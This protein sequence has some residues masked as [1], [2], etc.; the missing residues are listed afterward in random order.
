M[1][2]KIVVKSLWMD[3]LLMRLS[4]LSLCL[5]APAF[6]HASWFLVMSDSCSPLYGLYIPIIILNEVLL[7][8]V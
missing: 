1:L 2:F 3:S 5:P 8:I 7:I 4:L 6:R